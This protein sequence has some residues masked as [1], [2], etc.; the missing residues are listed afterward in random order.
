MKNL[1]LALALLP[2]L[3]MA[4]VQEPI[5]QARVHGKIQKAQNISGAKTE[6]VCEFDALIPVYGTSL[7]GGEYLGNIARC[8]SKEGGTELSVDLSGFISIVEPQANRPATK[9]V[10]LGMGL[11]GPNG[12]FLGTGNEKVGTAQLDLKY[13]DLYLSAD[14]AAG[15]GGVTT[16][17]A[18]VYLEDSAK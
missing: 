16:Y 6:P 1:L 15:T 4:A 11:W 9:V 8:D 12:E 17:Y 5:R 10:I 7:R 13:L 14:H 2:S 3:C 18:T